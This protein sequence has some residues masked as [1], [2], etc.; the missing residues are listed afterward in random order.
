[1]CCDKTQMIQFV[2]KKNITQTDI[3]KMS[4]GSTL[5]S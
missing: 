1:M 3:N 5:L 2:N 4:F